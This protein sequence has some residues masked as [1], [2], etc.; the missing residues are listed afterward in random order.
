MSNNLAVDPR[1]YPESRLLE[2]PRTAQHCQAHTE[3]LAAN[4]EVERL[5][6]GLRAKDKEIA[7]LRNLL[8][9]RERQLKRLQEEK[10]HREHGAGIIEGLQKA[11]EASDRRH[12]GSVESLRENLE[13][14]R[15]TI[16]GFQKIFDDRMNSLES[17][18]RERRGYI[19]I[20]ATPVIDVAK[21][22]ARRLTDRKRPSAADISPPAK[23]HQLEACNVVPSPVADH[24][25]YDDIFYDA[26]DT[27]NNTMSS[28]APSN[29][30]STERTHH[31]VALVSSIP[32]DN[33]SPTPVANTNFMLGDDIEDTEGS[34]SNNNNNDP[35]DD[36]ETGNDVVATVEN[37]DK[38]YAYDADGNMKRWDELSPAV[39]DEVRGFLSTRSDWYGK[40]M[41]S[42]GKHCLNQTKT[43]NHITLNTAVACKTCAHQHLLCVSKVANNILALRP[44]CGLDRNACNS[45]SIDSVE[46]FRLPQ[47]IQAPSKKAKSGQYGKV[48]DRS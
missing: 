46:F 19:S 1:S 30:P 22:I 28:A 47:D 38:L 2:V 10:T 40:L 23:R 29:G 31:D 44:L 21:G 9:D 18:P 35:A 15:K 12:T 11:L 7:N 13:S 8:D 27:N 3:L 24:E 39:Q 16:Q 48:N 37:L 32:R 5:T 14:L 41:R 33:A 42:F 43:A 34:I 25:D 17:A 4:R 45:P 20:V 6:D 26:V 36:D